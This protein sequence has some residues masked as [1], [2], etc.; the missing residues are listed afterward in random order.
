M[1]TAPRDR[2]RWGNAA[3]GDLPFA[4]DIDGD[5]QADPAVWRASSGT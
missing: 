3:L 1:T 4:A 5:G 2:C